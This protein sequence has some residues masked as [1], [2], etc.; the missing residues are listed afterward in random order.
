MSP[1]WGASC[2]GV[3]DPWPKKNPPR[4]VSGP[5]LAAWLSAA[6]AKMLEWEERLL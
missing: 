5:G 2:H 6:V 1:S 4:A 3:T